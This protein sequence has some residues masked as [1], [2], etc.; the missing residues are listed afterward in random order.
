ML[1]TNIISTVILI[2]YIFVLLCVLFAGNVSQKTK[3]LLYI[4]IASLVFIMGT[5]WIG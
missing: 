2:I 1:I 5:L 4:L 3:N